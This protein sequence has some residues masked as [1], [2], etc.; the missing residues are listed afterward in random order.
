MK[1]II[2]LLLVGLLA[3]SSQLLYG[4]G[5]VKLYVNL[6]A[7]GLGNGT[8]WAN[9]FLSLQSALQLSQNNPQTEYEI[10]V[11]EGTYT[12]G[13]SRFDR[14]VIRG[15]VSIYGGFD[16]TE[17]FLSDRVVDTDGKFTIHETVLSGEIG[18]AG[19]P[20][21]N[22][23]RV[24][25]IE[26][27]ISGD[28]IL[29]GMRISD[30]YA[31]IQ[32]PFNRGAGIYAVFQTFGVFVE[33]NIKNCVLSDN[34]ALDRG[35]AIE[36]EGGR[37][38]LGVF[39]LLGVLNFENCDLTQ[40]R[41]NGA[42]GAIRMVFGE[43]NF[44]KC[45]FIQ[46]RV[47]QGDGG[48]LYIGRATA[49]FDQCVFESNQS[50][51]N[52]GLA[53]I[54][55]STVKFTLCQ[56][57]GNTTSGEGGGPFLFAST[58]VFEDCVFERNRASTGGGLF[59]DVSTIIMVRDSFVLNSAPQGAGANYIST[60]GEIRD[61]FFLRN[62]SS[63]NGGGLYLS[64]STAEIID[65]EFKFNRARS[66][67]GGIMNR[68]SSSLIRN[69]IFEGDTATEGGGIMNEAFSNPTVSN[70]TFVGNCA[71]FGDGT[72]AGA[73][74]GFA[75]LFNSDAIID[76][77]SFIDNNAYGAAGL[78]NRQSS[79]KVSHC[80]FEGN[81]ALEGAA[82]SNQEFSNTEISY[83]Y[84]YDNK[85]NRPFFLPAIGGAILNIDESNPTISHSTFRE[86]YA[87]TQGA[88]VLNKGNSN[89]MIANCTFSANYI[90]S[91]TVGGRGSAIYSI[92]GDSSVQITSSTFYQN[93]SPNGGAIA[94][95]DNTTKLKNCI[96]ANNPGGN[97]YQVDN[98]SVLS[99]LGY[100]LFSDTSGVNMLP[101]GSDIY[102]TSA[103]PIDPLLDTL[104]LYSGPTPVHPPLPNSPVLG[105][106]MPLNEIDTKIDQRGYSRIRGSRNAQTDIGAF[107]AQST[108]VFSSK[109]PICLGDDAFYSLPEITFT[110]STGGA[111]AIGENQSI[112]ISLPDELEFEPGAGTVECEGLGL[113]ACSIDIMSNSLSI[114]YTRSYDTTL[115]RIHIR[116]LG[117][118]ASSVADFG[119]FSLLRTGGDALQYENQVE[120]SISIAQLSVVPSFALADGSY[121]ESFENDAGEWTPDA[122]SSL[123]EW[124]A[125]QG[126]V[127]NQAAS[128]VNAWM[129]DLDKLYPANDTSWLASP[130]FDFRGT[131]NPI[132]GMNIWSDSEDGF[133]G[134]ILQMSLDA[135]D[136]WQAVGNDKSG[137]EWY[138]SATIF[139]NPGQQNTLEQYG[140]SGRDSSW[141]RARIKLSGLQNEDAV[142]FRLAFG[143]IAVVDTTLSNDGFA[144]DDFFI[145]ESNKKVLLEHF[146]SSNQFDAN[147]R[148]SA[149]VA[150]LA[151]LII[152]IQ[153]H[154]KAG[155]SFYDQNPAGPR[156]R[157]LYYSISETGMAVVDGQDF[158]GRTPDL[159][160]DL[161][162]TSLLKESPI[163]IRI[164]TTSAE[165]VSISSS[166]D[167]T[168]ELIVQVAIVEH[169]EE[170]PYVLRKFLPDAAGTSYPFWA[171]DITETLDLSWQANDAL[172]P[173][174][175]V[176]NY[177][178][179]EVV[180]FVQNRETKEIYQVA[181][182]PV[183]SGL[184]DPTALREGNF[185]GLP[186]AQLKLYPNPASTSVNID[187][188]QFTESPHQVRITDL[189]GRS[190]VTMDL[191]AGATQYKLPIGKLAAGVYNLELKSATES[192][193]QER[194]IVLP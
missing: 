65:S 154:I 145:G 168:E 86:N 151:G 179:L 93:S 12:P 23:F 87:R 124:G 46:N 112:I 141:R 99:S 96:V 121:D 188:G 129:T 110:D 4:Q 17:N 165:S 137:L 11:A 3:C 148:I 34:T 109:R 56:I 132:I 53:F 68:G 52:G 75:N 58:A 176:E 119:E 70:C 73:G 193:L 83:C 128:G 98:A 81:T 147:D 142:R 178:S 39:Q 144:M 47:F 26:D 89:P 36:Y 108:Y 126:A 44:S 18:Q 25:E 67:G 153:F 122:P 170:Q 177:D 71:G 91:S 113:S 45:S 187:F 72:C 95:E 42:G 5:A 78:L 107:E 140:W 162:E 191:N 160:S 181:T 156:A 6:Q 135:G 158:M 59:S 118:K 31:N 40:N 33:V 100:N 32:S 7:T 35:G 104:G 79:P 21:D 16:G 20:T 143:S 182:S 51:T 125:P 48:G 41:V 88:G 131:S 161:L 2:R 105:A 27:Q 63:G 169:T 24:I 167:I 114:T 146:S 190:V 116:D 157:A 149:L 1:S 111:F 97:F 186:V 133:D 103:D 115:N 60:G 163:T 159:S 134:T 183:W 152:P 102:G 14:F 90:D 28:I 49:E 57:E 194:L 50:V 136:S 38:D 174:D 164:D 15:G 8:S 127:I 61:C 94:Q 150:P 84:F 185:P 123:W 120:D 64:G 180:V 138:N 82:M 55:N 30:G 175:I 80:Y 37:F 192:L 166:R 13:N 29:D 172:A 69:C 74:G 106:G 92:G 155:D 85:A 139:A 173:A 43:A 117:L 22:S 66:K 76:S 101:L 62:N 171:E 9:A 54:A 77:C 189:Q 19:N 10:W 184:L 130:C